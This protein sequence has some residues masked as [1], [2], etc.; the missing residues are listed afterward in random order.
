MKNVLFSLQPVWL[1]M[2]GASFYQIEMVE[3]RMEVGGARCSFN[4]DLAIDM[5]AFLAV[6]FG[7]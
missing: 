7:H 3:K 2:L 5:A 1:Q 4:V 6:F